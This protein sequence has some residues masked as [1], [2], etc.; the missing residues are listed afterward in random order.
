MT[1]LLDQMIEWEEGQLSEAETV[2][3][4]QELVNSGLA[5]ELQGAYG[6]QAADLIKAGL[7]TA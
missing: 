5:W 1:D 6:R 2:A 7:V 4:F 3:L